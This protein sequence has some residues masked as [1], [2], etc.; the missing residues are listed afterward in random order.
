MAHHYRR[1][2][3]GINFL[4]GG[5]VVAVGFLLFA[6]VGGTF[7]FS[8]GGAPNVRIDGPMASIAQ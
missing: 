4:L 6:I 1:L 5:T 8:I 3:R 2:P 7:D